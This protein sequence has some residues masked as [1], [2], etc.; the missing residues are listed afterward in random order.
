MRY[1]LIAAVL[2]GAGTASAQ[3]AEIYRCQGDNGETVFADEPCG[4]DAAK[5]EV[6]T[7]SSDRERNTTSSEPSRM[8]PDPGDREDDSDQ[9]QPG[10][11][12][13]EPET[14]EAEQTDEAANEP[15]NPCLNTASDN[16]IMRAGTSVDRIREACGTP[17]EVTT[18][19][20]LFDKKLQY[21]TGQRG[22]E[23]FIRD[24]K[25]VGHRTL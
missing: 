3:A 4:A 8:A 19:T 18:D 21:S 20:E 13:S 11:D 6:E 16:A 9:S 5:V 2:L 1:A 14:A 22:V 24:G 15:T 7:P 25:K 17:H 23:I 12:S 10:A